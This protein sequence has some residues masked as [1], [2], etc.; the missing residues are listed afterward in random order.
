MVQEQF[1]RSQP[2]RI[3]IGK[4]ASRPAVGRSLSPLV[5]RQHF[6]H[7]E[8]HASGEQQ[9]EQH[10]ED[11]FFRQSL[12]VSANFRSSNYSIAAL[13]QFSCDALPISRDNAQHQNSRT[14]ANR[15]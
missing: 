14:R 5:W 15:L 12:L 7:V 9:R 11:G 6:L 4:I 13:L 1:A 2:A 8:P 3:K 10:T